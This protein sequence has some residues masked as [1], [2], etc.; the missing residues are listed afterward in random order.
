MLPRLFLVE[1]KPI[2]P[3][4]LVVSRNLFD[5][6]KG[7]QPDLLLFQYVRGVLPRWLEVILK[8]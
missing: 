8:I 4:L 2:I 7:R 1:L 6:T 3:Y 5:F